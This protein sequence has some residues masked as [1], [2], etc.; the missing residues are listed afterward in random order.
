MAAYVAAAGALIAMY[1]QYESGQQQSKNLKSQAEWLELQA[2]YSDYMSN[3]QANNMLWQSYFEAG[4]MGEKANMARYE[5]EMT[6]GQAGAMSKYAYAKT[7]LAKESIALDES[8]AFDTLATNLSTK[9]AEQGKSGVRVNTGSSKS[10]LAE[11]WDKKS[12]EIAT[13]ADILRR[14]A[15]LELSQAL[16]NADIT[17]AKGTIQLNEADLM[18]SQAG[19][20]LSM[21]DYNAGMIKTKGLYDSTLTRAQA[22]IYRSGSDQAITAGWLGAASTGANAYTNYNALK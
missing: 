9:K 5:A 19:F 21:G 4:V 14:S 22:R 18:D 12:T 6:F 2:Q 3:M 15:D 20:L 13:G 17:K 8:K 11:Y 1:S 7:G 16:F 10:F